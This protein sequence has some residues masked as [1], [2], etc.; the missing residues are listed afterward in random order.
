MSALEIAVAAHDKEKEAWRSFQN[1][2]SVEELVWKEELA[3]YSSTPD[4]DDRVRFL[5]SVIG[6]LKA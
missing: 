6:E 4:C 1:L 5:C 2:A 3:K